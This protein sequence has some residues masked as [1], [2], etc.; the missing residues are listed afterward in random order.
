M[1]D[2]LCE[3]CD[4]KKA[5]MDVTMP[6]PIGIFKADTCMQCGLIIHE[7]FN[8]VNKIIKKRAE[9][10]G[11]TLPMD[12]ETADK[13]CQTKTADI[14]SKGENKICSNCLEENCKGFCRQI[15]SGNRE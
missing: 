9:L 6:L 15:P 13:V 12:G 10:M 1:K 3:V 8:A 7:N 5:E 14:K 2:K 4:E 11:I